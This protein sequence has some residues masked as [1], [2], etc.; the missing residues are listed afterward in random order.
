MYVNFLK[1]NL[2]TFSSCDMLIVQLMLFVYYV[3][4]FFKS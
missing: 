4:E 3:C 2:P 1:A